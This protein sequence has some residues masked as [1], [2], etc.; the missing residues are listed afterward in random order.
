M[1]LLCIFAALAVLFLFCAFLTLKCNL[2]AALAPLSALGIAVAWLTAAGMANLL[3]PGTVLLWAVFA[4]SGVWALVP[5]KGQ[6]PACR[7]QPRIRSDHRKSSLSIHSRPLLPM[8]CVILCPWSAGCEKAAALR[9]ESS[10]DL[11]FY[12]TGFS[13]RAAAEIAS[14]SS[15][16]RVRSTASRIRGSWTAS[17]KSAYPFA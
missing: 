15:M 3:L 8:V 12:D 6:R 16:F 5:H 9:Q 4:G 17:S 11:F 10:G 2:H 1:E 14:G 13:V 7:R